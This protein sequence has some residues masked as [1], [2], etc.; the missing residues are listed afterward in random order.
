MYK[1]NDFLIFFFL[2]LNFNYL[3]RN[4]PSNLIIGT[5]GRVGMK[6][7]FGIRARGT[8]TKIRKEN[9]VYF[10]TLNL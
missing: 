10:S 6:L 7:I 3:T 1:E 8:K 9:K 2:A 4:A 5:D